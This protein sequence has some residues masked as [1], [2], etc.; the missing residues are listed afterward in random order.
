MN[1]DKIVEFPKVEISDEERARRTL[2]EV[3][4]LTRLSPGEWRLWYKRGAQTLGI[5]PEVLREFIEAKLRDIAAEKRAAEAEKRRQEERVERQRTSAERDEKR[6]REGEQRDIEKDATRKAQEKSKAFADIA[7][8][9]SDRHEAKL[10]EL[11][12]RLG[13]DLAALR[14]EFSEYADTVDETETPS[15]TWHVEPW[16]DPIV[17]A[18][19]LQRYHCQDRSALCCT[20]T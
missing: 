20:S 3:D 5:E 1:G 18:A 15:A 4:R 19:L 14:D 8:L 10:S 16:P 6:K 12:K 13:E 11:A 7:K 17:T 2:V 9:P